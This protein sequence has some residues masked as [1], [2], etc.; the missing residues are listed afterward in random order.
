MKQRIM[1]KLRAQTGASIT[2][3]LL[4]FLVCSVLCSVILVAATASAGR[5]ARIRDMDERYYAVTSAAEVLKG[6]L[7]GKTA[8]SETVDGNTRDTTVYLK[9]GDPLSTQ[10]E[11]F[12]ADAAYR[13]AQDPVDKLSKEPLELS[14]ESNGPLDAEAEKALAVRIEESLDENGTITFAMKNAEGDPYILTLTFNAD[15]QQTTSTWE[16]EPEDGSEE[17]PTTHVKTTTTW[18]WHLAGITTGQAAGSGGA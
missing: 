5:M 6:L 8:I 10:T 14:V 13:L 2:F 4:L 17:E 15:K 9:D 11:S 12:Q 18:T 3:A 1:Q 16:E 7:D